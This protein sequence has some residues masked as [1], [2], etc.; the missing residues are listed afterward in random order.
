M[1]KKAVA[2]AT[3]LFFF[4][5]GKQVGKKIVSKYAESW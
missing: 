3:V 2:D 5:I 4:R 1:I